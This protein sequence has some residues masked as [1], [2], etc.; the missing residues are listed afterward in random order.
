[1]NSNDNTS[2]INLISVYKKKGFALTQLF[3]EDA[4]EDLTLSSNWADLP[5]NRK[6]FGFPSINVNP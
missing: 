2:I 5:Y 1:M 6:S 3:D 4:F